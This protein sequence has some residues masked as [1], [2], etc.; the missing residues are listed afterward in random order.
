[1]MSR[2]ESEE[3]DM[4][5]MPPVYVRESDLDRQKRADPILVLAEDDGPP[6][7]EVYYV[8]MSNESL[9]AGRSLAEADMD[10]VLLMEVYQQFITTYPI[11]V[12]RDKDDYLE[13]KYGTIKSITF[14]WND[15]GWPESE[16][17][18]QGILDQFPVGF[19]KQFQYGLGLKW[20]YRFLIDAISEIDG[21]SHIVFSKTEETRTE[22]DTYYFDIREYQSLRKYIDT[23]ARKYQKEAHGDKRLLC[24]TN[25]L[26]KHDPQKYPL[27]VKDFKSGGLYNSLAVT[28]SDV[29]LEKKDRKIALRLVGE[30][31]EELANDEPCALLRLK[32]E[33]EQ[34]TLGKL[35]ATF[36]EMLCK[37]LTE[38]QWQ[39]FFKDNS[40]ILGLAFSYPI[41]LIQD[42]A[43]VGGSDISGVGVKIADFL[44]ANRFTG[45]LALFE[46]KKPDVQ[47]LA[48]VE[49]RTNLYRSSKEL[50]GA[51]A[52]VQDQKFQIQNNFATLAYQ[53]GWQDVHPFSVHCIVVIGRNVTDRQQRKSFEFTRHALKDV[54][55]VTFD[56]LLEKLKELHKIFAAD[57]TALSEDVPF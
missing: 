23:I 4:E 6:C 25:I 12:R 43:H 22:G 39:R 11:N 32:A 45:N 40:F 37:Q 17:D 13:Q 5:N 42:Q 51:I 49:Y 57:K 9:D 34:V 35:I 50:S 53:S 52:Q 16:D 10:R 14:D 46:I 20:E 36:E 2:E 33:I 24:Y 56:E 1:M 54:H 55:V 18:V 26:R 31:K 19:S 38:T 41:M 27:K 48:E 3:S 7:V 29:K 30:N 28:E 15:H 44:V 21:V 47:M 8:A